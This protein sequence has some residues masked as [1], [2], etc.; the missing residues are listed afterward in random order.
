M[1]K[2][3]NTFMKFIFFAFLLGSPS[4]LYSTGLWHTIPDQAGPVGRVF[5][6]SSADSF[7]YGSGIT[8]NY[9][10]GSANS[11]EVVFGP[12]MAGAGH[13]FTFWSWEETENFFYPG[14]VDTRRIYVSTDAGASWIFARELS[15][16]EKEW[17]KPAILLSE[18]AGQEVLIKLVFNSVDNFNNAFKGWYVDEAWEG[19]VSASFMLSEALDNYSLIFTTG[20]G[21]DWFGQTV[22]SRFGGTAAKS[23]AIGNNQTTFIRTNVAGPGYISFYYMVSSE[24]NFDYFNVYLDGMAQLWENVSGTEMDNYWLKVSVFV[25]AGN[26]E[27]KWLYIKDE[28]TAGGEDSVWIDRVVFIPGGSAPVIPTISLATPTADGTPTMSS[29]RTVSPSRTPSSTATPTF[30]PAVVTLNEALDNYPLSLIFGGVYAWSGQQDTYYYGNDAA[31]CSGA[32]DGQYSSMSTSINGYCTFKFVWKVSCEENYD[33]LSLYIDGTEVDA[34]TGETSWEEMSYDLEAGPHTITW[35]YSKD[36]D[37]SAGLDSAWVD[38]VEV[39]VTSP[40][41]T[42]TRTPS[43][44]ASPSSTH[45]PVFSPTIT[46]TATRTSTALLVS[47]TPELG[48]ALDN[49][50]L[51]FSGNGWTGQAEKFF[52]GGDSAQSGPTGDSASNTLEAYV[53]GMGTVSFHWQTDTDWGDKLTFYVDGVVAAEKNYRYTWAG[54]DF[55]INTAGP[56]LL[57]WVYSKDEYNNCQYSSNCHDRVWVDKVNFV[58]GTHTATPTASATPTA[59]NTFTVTCTPTDAGTLTV[60]PEVSPTDTGSPYPTHSATRTF[61]PTVGI[62]EAVDNASLIFTTGGGAWYGEIN[63]G[64]YTNGSNARSGAIGNSQY[65]YLETRV[66]GPGTISF[67][68][69]LSAEDADNFQMSI[70]SQGYDSTVSYGL[71]T[72][73]T[74]I[75]EGINSGLTVIRWLYIKDSSSSS[76]E[77]CL[78]LDNIV[79]ISGT[80]TPWPSWPTNT[81]VYTATRTFTP[82]P[83]VPAPTLIPVDEAQWYMATANSGMGMRY[84]HKCTVF[85]NKMWL[86]GGYSGSLKGDVW[87]SSDGALWS[88]INPDAFSDRYYHSAVSFKGKIWVTGGLGNNIREAYNDVWSSA[89]GAVWKREIQNASFH[90]RYGHVCLVFNNRMWVAGGAYNDEASGSAVYLNDVWS[91]GDGINWVNEKDHAAFSPRALHNGV[92][93]NGKMW[94]LGGAYS[95]SNYNA[96]NGDIWSSS[97]GRNWV[98]EA[99]PAAFGKKFVSAL[100]VHKGKLWIISGTDAA[101]GGAYEDDVWYTDDGVNWVQAVEH[102]GFTGRGGHESLEFDGRLWVIGGV[103]GDYGTGWSADV[104]YSPFKGTPTVTQ[105]VTASPTISPTHT[106]SQ[107]HTVSPALSRTLSATQT[108]AISATHTLLN[109]NTITPTATATG[110]TTPVTGPVPGTGMNWQLASSAAFSEGRFGHAGAVFNGKMWVIGG[111]SLSQMNNDVYSSVDGINWTLETASAAFSPRGFFTCVVMAGKIWIMGGMDNNGD[112]LSEVWSSSDGVNWSMETDTAGFG[113]RYWHSSIVFGGKIW[114]IG[115]MNTFVL[116]NDI[117]SSADGITWTIETGSPGFDERIGAALM[118]YNGKIWLMNGINMTQAFN[119]VWSSSDGIL[120]TM[121]TA[122]AAYTPRYSTSVLDH[123]GR[124]WMIGGHTETDFMGEVWSSGDCVNWVQETLAADFTARAG[125]VGMVYD[126]RLWVMGGDSG[127]MENDV[128]FSPPQAVTTATQTGTVTSSATFTATAAMTSTPEDTPTLTQ[129]ETQSPAETITPTPTITSTQD[130]TSTITQTETQSPVETI[131]PTPTIT[132][133]QDGTSTITRTETQSPVETTTLT[134]TITS[135]QDGTSTITQTETQSPVETTTPT[136]TVEASATGTPTVTITSTPVDTATLTQTGTPSATTTQTF[137]DTPSHTRTM[138]QE[139]TA[140]QSASA[141]FTATGTATAGGTVTAT[142]TPYPTPAP[143]RDVFAVIN[144][145]TY[146]NPYSPASSAGI[147][148]SY[149]LTRDVNSAVMYVYSNSFRLVRKAALSGQDTAGIKIKTLARNLL[150]EFGNGTYFYFIESESRDGDRI[151]SK[152]GYLIII[153]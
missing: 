17:H 61:L 29:T 102:A 97:D 135:T 16:L 13:V 26:H 25:P 95:G 124:F 141:V 41:V 116:L 137:A 129:T 112:L 3:I 57:Q 56:H 111:Q 54:V 12:Y 14:A 6:S 119:D 52:Y 123:A 45:S 131:T 99:D 76:G 69:K 37:I 84:G 130:G 86:L 66:N 98:K 128:W 126:D 36:V 28:N 30:T 71:G 110:T 77:D 117:W 19:A 8:G 48:E 144:A 11:G 79:F 140:T 90:N 22:D 81:P 149:E 2:K 33:Y 42:P 114:V 80:A 9:D 58:N 101:Y 59:Q 47:A 18:Y 152:A 94:V 46:P 1:I 115:G 151:R 39:I 127:I 143:T 51:T 106:I 75:T 49:Y 134:P 107:T 35:V 10:T 109:T 78:R 96:I 132:S 142:L 105:T 148:V 43:H 21:A 24:Q 27:I 113:N 89:D 91:T 60:T 68:A 63:A 70:Q 20:G 15:G 34:I 67:Y 87:S 53:S 121:E 153:R 7:W 118:V 40:T 108:A 136:P 62:N 64:A 147:S 146:P 120:W 23:G 82:S 74:R 55:V 31:R 38:R 145:L 104:W 139:A 32:A 122:S 85:N 4:L 138:T 50:S 125:H 103:F 5:S 83:A 150:E 65:S 44:T 133:T 93:F 100:A 73:W 72:G 92:V 88:R